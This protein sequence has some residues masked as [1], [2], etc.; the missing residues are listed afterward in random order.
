MAVHM[1]QTT[2]PFTLTFRGYD[3]AEVDEYLESV[4]DRQA[5]MS[6]A[7]EEADETIVSL[8][9]Q[10]HRQ[11]QRVADLE[12]CVR[13]ES[14]RTI[15]AL[16]ERVT[17]ILEQAEE[18]AAETV[19][20]AQQEADAAR[21]DAAST[22]ER[23]TQQATARATE[24]EATAGAMVRAATERAR[25]IEMEARRSA[26]RI[27]D[28][29]EAHAQAR[30][31][32]IDQWVI[33]VRT[34]IK[35]EQ[36]QAAE[37]FDTVRHQRQTELADLVARRDGLLHDLRTICESVTDMAGAY[38]SPE[39]PVEGHGQ[40]PAV[41]SAEE[42]EGDGREPAPMSDDEAEPQ[43]NRVAPEPMGNGG[44]TAS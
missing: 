13:D 39:G 38:G 9:S 7:L 26:T 23:V 12:S 30:I 15:A 8:E 3:K 31:S 33:R 36:I 34:Q 28:E 22:A 14:P 11:A 10:L 6:T 25:Q 19:T 42:V 43:N 44:G 17:L 16:G 29:A 35:A 1:L 40:E 32:D 24:L 27:L 18:A 4:W 2:Q 21:R 37:E 41:G 5:E 20:A